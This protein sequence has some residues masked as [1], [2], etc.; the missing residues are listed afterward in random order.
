MRRHVLVFLAVA[1]FPAM[2]AAREWTDDT[3][4]YRHEAEYLHEANGEVWLRDARGMFYV[5]DIERLS[6]ADRAYVASRGSSARSSKPGTPAKTLAYRIPTFT[7]AN[8]PAPE[9]PTRMMT[10][11]RIA[12][13]TGWHRYG[14]HS[15]VAHHPPIKPCPTPPDGGKRI[16]Q[17]RWS[18]FHLVCRDPKPAICGT[19]AY[20]FMD[21]HGCCHEYLEL[22]WFRVQVGTF[23]LLY[24]VAD[25][26]PPLDIKYW[27]FENT[28]FSKHHYNVSY[29]DGSKNV[30]VWYDCA[31][32][33][34]PE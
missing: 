23:W 27:L 30:W 18:T 6:Q 19:G 4:Q 12:K 8:D 20:K 2:L 17:G 14:G 5:V 13:L 22:L 31:H 9:S 25:P 33:R 3:G 34:I 11:A 26:A 15:H 28:G 7:A 29:W 1:L 10:D 21:H 24:E 16:Y 32:L